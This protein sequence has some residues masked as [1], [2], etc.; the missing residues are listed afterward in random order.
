MKQPPLMRGILF[1]LLLLSIARPNDATILYTDTDDYVEDS[2]FDEEVAGW[3]FDLEE[4]ILTEI[5]Q[6]KANAKDSRC[7]EECLLKLSRRQDRLE[8]LQMFL[9]AAIDLVSGP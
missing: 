6:F 7:G 8:S 1:F 9:S 4:K 3:V 2:F 5:E